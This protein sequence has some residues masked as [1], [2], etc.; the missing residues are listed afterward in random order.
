[1]VLKLTIQQQ[2]EHHASEHNFTAN[3]WRI[4]T[5]I[6]MLRKTPS[7]AALRSAFESMTVNTHL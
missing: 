6:G 7:D 5:F 2:L 4:L 3:L 1:M